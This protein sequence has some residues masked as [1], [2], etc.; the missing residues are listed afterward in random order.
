[1]ASIM[2]EIHT[3]LL[4]Q[5]GLT[6][7]VKHRIYPNAIPQDCELPAVSYEVT[8]DSP[9]HTM[10]SDSANPRK[11]LI[12]YHIWANTYTSGKAIAEQIRTALMDKTGT[13]T[14]RTIQRVF[15]E[16]EYDL[17]EAD[18]EIHHIV[19]DFIIWYT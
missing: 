13:L 7:L 19:L 4:T 14:T 2:E 18:I 1:M 5:T 12:S 10:S 17:Y 3:Y 15:W 9:L 16:N 11:P 6:A 8:N